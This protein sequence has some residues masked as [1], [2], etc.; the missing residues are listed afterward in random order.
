MK[1]NMKRVPVEHKLGCG[2]ASGIFGNV[3][4]VHSDPLSPLVAKNILSFL[5]HDLAPTRPPS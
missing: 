1:K 5:F 2:P 4:D 3:T